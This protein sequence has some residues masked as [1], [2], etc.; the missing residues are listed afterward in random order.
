MEPYNS[1]N[2][3]SW[4]TA[5]HASSGCTRGSQWLQSGSCREIGISRGFKCPSGRNELGLFS[6]TIA[7]QPGGLARPSVADRPATSWLGAKMNG[8]VAL[9]LSSAHDSPAPAAQSATGR[10]SNPGPG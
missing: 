9:S 8:S 6:W 1:K 10:A 5:P 3:L 4:K 2:S 7:L